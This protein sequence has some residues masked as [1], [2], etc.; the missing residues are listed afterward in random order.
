MNA[1]NEV[2]I[3]EIEQISIN[4]SNMSSMTLMVACL[5]DEDSARPSA[6]TISNAFHNITDQLDRLDGDLQRVIQFIIDYEKENKA[7]RDSL[8]A[9][10]DIDNGLMVNG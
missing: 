10:T 6:E 1:L 5:L 4:V 9:E 2:V 8:S 3:N 7:A